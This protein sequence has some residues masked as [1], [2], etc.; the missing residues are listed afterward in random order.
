MTAQQY[1]DYNLHKGEE[2]GIKGYKVAYTNALD[3][4]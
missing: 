1:V 2:F 4:P 3:K